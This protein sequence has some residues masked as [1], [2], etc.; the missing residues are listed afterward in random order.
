MRAVFGDDEERL[1]AIAETDP[2]AAEAAAGAAMIF[3]NASLHAAINNTLQAADV[4]PNRNAF[5]LVATG[6]G[7]K[8]V[9]ATKVGE[10][11]QI[12]SMISVD[13]DQHIEGGV[14]IKATW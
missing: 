2:A 3:D 8:A 1:A 11:W 5:A 6:A 7:V 10:H 9:L 14:E 4:G 12:D 13:H